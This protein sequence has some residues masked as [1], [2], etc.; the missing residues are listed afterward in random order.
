[1]L[2]N[3]GRL[4]CG[5]LLGAQ[6]RLLT[7]WRFSICSWVT[8]PCGGLHSSH[9]LLHAGLCLCVSLD[10]AMLD[11]GYEAAQCWAAFLRNFL[12]AQ[13]WLLTSWCCSSAADPCGGHLSGHLLL[14]GGLCLCVVSHGS[15][16]RRLFHKPA[17]VAVCI[18]F[19]LCYGLLFRAILTARTLAS[20]CRHFQNTTR[21][22]CG[23]AKS[24]TAG[25][26][27]GGSAQR[28]CWHAVLRLPLKLRVSSGAPQRQDRHVCCPGADRSRP[29]HGQIRY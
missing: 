12:G 15:M 6:L 24:T 19:S 11:F 4:S 16:V 10:A 23:I 25:S 5:N 20:C 29:L 18:D 2:L 7:S 28:S 3:D 1:M 8:G 27:L 9:L 14:H 22:R 17:S 21:T 26:P 13:L